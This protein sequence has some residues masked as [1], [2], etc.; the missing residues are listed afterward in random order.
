MQFS[1][2]KLER[3]KA[4]IS[5]KKKKK[6]KRKKWNARNKIKKSVKQLIKI[7]YVDLKNFK[8]IKNWK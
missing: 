7:K 5:K 8:A 2:A 6:F 1:L 3:D 4:V